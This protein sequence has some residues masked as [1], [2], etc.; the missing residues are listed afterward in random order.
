MAEQQVSVTYFTKE[1]EPGDARVYIGTA[2]ALAVIIAV[3]AVKFYF[4]KQKQP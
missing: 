4:D 1:V 3:A 2:I